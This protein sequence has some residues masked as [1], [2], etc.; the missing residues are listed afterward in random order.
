[1]RKGKNNNNKNNNKKKKK[2][3]PPTLSTIYAKLQVWV[4]ICNIFLFSYCCGFFLLIWN[5]MCKLKDKK[6]MIMMK[7]F[8][9]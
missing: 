1:M 8:S 6:S 3:Q 4:S 5:Y 2:D 7:K 9:F